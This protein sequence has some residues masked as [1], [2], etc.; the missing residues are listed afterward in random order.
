MG[1]IARWRAAW[2]M[3]SL[4]RK[5]LI[6][7][8]ASTLLSMLG[9]AMLSFV[10]LSLV[11]LASP[12]AKEKQA[13]TGSADQASDGSQ[14]GDTKSTTAARKPRSATRSPFRETEN[15]APTKQ[16]SDE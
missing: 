1:T 9:I 7:V 8:C 16:E 15:A 13:S 4:A 5:T 10:T 2:A 11:K 3:A 12:A 14:A 6:S